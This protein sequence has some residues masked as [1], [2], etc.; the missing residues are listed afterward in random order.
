MTHS[1]AVPAHTHTTPLGL[2]P[3]PNP[4]PNPGQLTM[5]EWITYI[6]S[7]GDQATKVMQRYPPRKRSSFNLNYSVL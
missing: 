2:H 3:N 1:L 6:E 5:E 4:N 7:K